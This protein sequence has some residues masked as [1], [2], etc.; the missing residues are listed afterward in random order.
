MEEEGGPQTGGWDLQVRVCDQ[1]KCYSTGNGEWPLGTSTSV[2]TGTGRAGITR[3]VLLS[4]CESGPSKGAMPGQM[5]WWLP[6]VGAGS[7][8][9]ILSGVL[10]SVVEAMFALATA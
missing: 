7:C 9:R 4:R 8:L 2:G 10:C 3:G 6:L 1:A 5:A